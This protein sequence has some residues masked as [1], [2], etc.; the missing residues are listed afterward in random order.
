MYEIVLELEQES[1]RY[2]ADNSYVRV[3]L[4]FQQG[5]RP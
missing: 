5:P 3:A 1:R 2:K 4:A